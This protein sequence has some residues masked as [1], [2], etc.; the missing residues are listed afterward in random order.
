MAKSLGAV[1][2]SGGTGAQEKRV[3][4]AVAEVF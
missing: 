4:E 3:V 1:G 2:V